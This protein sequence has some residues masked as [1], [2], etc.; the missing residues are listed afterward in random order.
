MVYLFADPASLLHQ[1][2]GAML[3]GYFAETGEKGGKAITELETI[4]EQMDILF[5][6]STNEEL[7]N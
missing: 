3:D 1:Y 5:N 4:E 6:T 2:T 7:G